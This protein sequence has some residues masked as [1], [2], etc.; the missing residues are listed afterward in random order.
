MTPEVVTIISL[1]PRNL[2]EYDV[3]YQGNIQKN[4]Q[5]IRAIA[6]NIAYNKTRNKSSSPQKWSTIALLSTIKYLN[7][8]AR[9][10]ELLKFKVA[11]PA[12]NVIFIS[13]DGL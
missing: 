7:Y 6:Y 12:K 3:A 2:F 5:N 8:F 9:G 13:F 11:V 1:P 4:I 10:A